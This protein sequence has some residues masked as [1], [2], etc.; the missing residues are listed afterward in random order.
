MSA[1]YDAYD[2]CR[3]KLAEDRMQAIASMPPDKR[4]ELGRYVLAS[5]DT[6]W[7]EGDSPEAAIADAAASC[8]GHNAQSIAHGMESG[9]LFVFFDLYE[10]F[11]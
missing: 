11:G 3:S 7:G 2:Y 8:P 9:R 6:I 10:R 4:A 5:Y 1:C